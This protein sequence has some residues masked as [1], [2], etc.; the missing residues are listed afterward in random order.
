MAEYLNSG[1]IV[2]CRAYPM[3]KSLLTTCYRIREALNPGR[4]RPGLT[5]KAWVIRPVGTTGINLSFHNHLGNPTRKHKDHCCNFGQERFHEV[6][7]SKHARLPSVDYSV[8]T[9]LAGLQA[10][11]RGS[12]HRVFDQS[13][14]SSGFIRSSDDQRR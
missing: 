11:P 7:Q 5:P 8:R 3:G 13:L 10:I 6:V 2:H 14:S 9:S 12:S 4:P 1:L